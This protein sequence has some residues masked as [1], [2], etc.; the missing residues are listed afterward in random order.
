MALNRISP[1]KKNACIAPYYDSLCQGQKYRQG[2]QPDP[3]Q[4]FK[5]YH[6]K[7]LSGRESIPGPLS[8]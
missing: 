7:H 8:K 6:S 3:E 5:F 2:Q 4:I 1:I